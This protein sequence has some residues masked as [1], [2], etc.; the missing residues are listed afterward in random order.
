M[1]LTNL[2]NNT[3]IK[4]SDFAGHVLNFVV[5]SLSP[6]SPYFWLALAG[7]IFILPFQ[8]KFWK[9]R[10]AELRSNG[11]H[12]LVVFV[13]FVGYVSTS[14]LYAVVWPLGLPYLLSRDNKAVLQKPPKKD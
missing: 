12:E 6:P 8:F 5:T 3:L 7:L 10:E 13:S 4:L 9:Q 14:A 11:S 1:N 2:F